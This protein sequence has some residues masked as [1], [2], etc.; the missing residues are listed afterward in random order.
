MPLSH[1]NYQLCH[2]I[3]A[4]GVRFCD[5]S[6]KVSAPSTSNVIDKEFWQGCISILCPVFSSLTKG[7]VA[8]HLSSIECITMRLNVLFKGN[9]YLSLAYMS[10]T[11]VGIMHP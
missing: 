5:S 9:A 10:T 7:E 11:L 3:K 8:V 1:C 2:L 4:E 6:K